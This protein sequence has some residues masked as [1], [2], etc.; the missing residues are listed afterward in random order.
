[1]CLL[2]KRTR[3]K[4]E[5]KECVWKL[6][7]VFRITVLGVNTKILLSYPLWGAC[8]L[9]RIWLAG[10]KPRVQHPPTHIPQCGRKQCSGV[11]RRSNDRLQLAT[12]KV[13]VSLK[14]MC[15]LQPKGNLQFMPIHHPTRCTLSCAC[16]LLRKKGWINSE[17]WWNPDLAGAR[18]IG[19]S[20]VPGCPEILCLA[21][22]L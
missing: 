9:S 6:L 10:H 19:T 13:H 11:K 20:P 18:V 7:V 4:P 12:L 3:S 17:Y 5:D 21:H 22:I 14:K 15:L 1:M 2:L 16:A 8:S